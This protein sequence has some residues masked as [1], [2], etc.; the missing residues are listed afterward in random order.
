MSLSG[1]SAGCNTIIIIMVTLL[2]ALRSCQQQTER[3]EQLPA[4]AKFWQLP[5]QQFASII[6]MEEVKVYTLK[7]P[8]FAETVSP[9]ESRCFIFFVVHTILQSMSSL[10]LSGS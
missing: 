3:E 1:V 6:F 8:F 2:A 10:M 9:S 7:A 4:F 5:I